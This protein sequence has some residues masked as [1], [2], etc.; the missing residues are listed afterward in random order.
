M[1]IYAWSQS[2]AL[3]YGHVVRGNQVGWL[4]EKGMTN[5][6]YNGGNV[7][8]VEGWDE[9]DWNARLDANVLPEKLWQER[10]DRLLRD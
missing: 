4:N 5:G 9:N 10:D 1:G 7:G 8:K 2:K 3:S 6:C